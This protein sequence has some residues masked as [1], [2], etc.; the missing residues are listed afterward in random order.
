L[1]GGIDV[2]D[3][4]A[5][6]LPIPDPTDGIVRPPLSKTVLLEEGA[7]RFQAGAIYACQE[8]TQRGAMGEVSTPKQ[9][10]ERSL[11]GS[12]TMKEVSQGPFS[13]NG[14]ANEQSQKVE[15]F[16]APE[17]PTHQPNLASEGL[18]KSFLCQVLGQDNYF[19]EPC[20]NRGTI[21]GRSLNFYARVRY[22]T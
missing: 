11:K 22:H 9:G 5:T 4:V 6:P 10:H 17:A 15:R 3:D 8:T 20:W 13:T 12:Q 7:K 14:V 19:S 18:E 16:I 21:H 2:K 1:T